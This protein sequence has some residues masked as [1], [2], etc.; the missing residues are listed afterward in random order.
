MQKLTS[1]EI[2]STF[3]KFFAAKDHQ[4]IGSSTLIPQNDPTLLFINSGMAPLKDYFLGVTKPPHRRLCN[5]QPCLRTTDIDDVGDRHHL[6]WFEMLGSWSIGDYY[7]EK[8]IEYA[9]EL[10]VQNFGFD[11]QRLYVSVFAGEPSWNL[12]P[13]ELSAKVWE[14]TGIS[15]ERIVF[16]GREDNF[17]GPAGE[18]GPCGPCTEVFYDCGESFGAS[19]QAGGEFDSSSRYIE[20]W[21]AGVF[22]EL[23]KTQNGGFEPLPLKSVDTGSGLERM[24]MVMNGGNDV[25][26]TDNLRPIMEVM[27]TYHQGEKNLRIL[28]DHLRAATLLLAEGVA[29]ANGGRGYVVRR[30]IRKCIA[31][32]RGARDDCT[33]IVET[34]IQVIKTM[35]ERH[36]QLKQAE[37]FIYKQYKK[38]ISDFEPLVQ[39]GLRLLT[40]RVKKLSSP[41]VPA[42]LVFELVATHGLPLE[43]IRTYLEKHNY[44]FSVQDYENE[45]QKHRDVSRSEQ[46]NKKIDTLLQRVQGTPVTEFVGYSQMQVEAKVLKLITAGKETDTVS[47]DDEF[48]FLVDKTPFYAEAGGQVGD[49]GLAST[50]NCEMIVLDVQKKNDIY[51]HRARLQRG[52]LR[53]G[54]VLQLY[55]DEEKRLLTRRNHSVTHLVQSALRQIIGEHVAQ[56]GSYVDEHK[57]R[58]DFQHDK[59][60]T[61]E[62][63]Q[64]VEKRVNTWIWQ[65]IARGTEVLP[66]AQA[67]KK[68]ALFMLGENY[69]EQVRTIS[70][71]S[72]SIEL[73]GGTH[74]ESTGEIGLMR[75][76]SESSIAKGIRRIEGVTGQKAL[77]LNQQDTLLL[78][79]ACELLTVGNDALLERIKKLKTKPT[80]VARNTSVSEEIQFETTGQPKLAVCI[81]RLDGD[82]KDLKVASEDRRKKYDVV[83]IFSLNADTYRVGIAASTDLS[84]KEVLARFFTHVDGKGGGRDTFAQGGGKHGNKTFT[85]LAAALQKSLP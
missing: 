21:N 67:I 42:S 57:F 24:A 56:K 40:E 85:E 18:F 6:T 19:Y 14:Q 63:C 7:K 26:Q 44:R 41:D 48:F 33:G 49:R 23:N 68:G 15:R 9:Y 76:T 75:I 32:V 59:A 72:A 54:E 37:N 60:L 79:Q 47:G 12:P 52:K 71:D 20:I 51:L 53:A 82:A 77:A 39:T 62:E 83:A 69:Q 70:F 30:L 1:T 74:V 8:A 3:L 65:N 80:S 34:V 36:P 58:F 22:I 28:T 78:R 17:W 43:I 38:E 55:V 11:P 25:Y 61:L 10:L 2:A 73:C 66:Y 27:A 45:W 13:D 84:A 31:I 35:Q 46:K 64:A 29:P 16:L 81:G 50:P 4:V 5:I